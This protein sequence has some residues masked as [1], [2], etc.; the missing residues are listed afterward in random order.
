MNHKKQKVFTLYIS[1]ILLLSILGLNG[2]I[3]YSHDL[4]TYC[5]LTKTLA[6]TKEALEGFL[7]FIGSISAIFKEIS[8]IAGF[9]V[10][11]LFIS[12]LLFS[13]V[14]S[15]VG[16]PK[17]KMSFLLALIT[18]NALW[19]LWEKSYN[20]SND[21]LTTIFK[22]NI[23]L[24][25]PVIAFL[26]LKR[27]LPLIYLRITSIL[28]RKFNLFK[29]R[30]H[31]RKNMIE[32]LKRYQDCSNEFEKSLIEDI[33]NATDERITLSQN[34]NRSLRELDEIVKIFKL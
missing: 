11:V 7:R 28:Y 29:K 1:I 21:Y 5:G 22:T 6:E 10:I 12:V 20:R 3:D 17:G 16:V 25:I 8:S 27:V 2:T 19:L 24:F 18:V 33:L 15:F 13:A 14:F 23:I 32:I 4:M 9:R 30:L 34:T 26:T 31:K